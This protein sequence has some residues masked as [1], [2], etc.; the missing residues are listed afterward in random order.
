TLAGSMEVIRGSVHDLKDDSIDL[1]EAM[2][3]I[4]SDTPYEVHFYCGI[5]NTDELPNDVKY[6]FLMAAKEALTNTTK[7]SDATQIKIT[8]QEHPVL[9]QLRIHDNGSRPPLKT[10]GMGL[11]NI[12]SRVGG[13]G[14]YCTFSYENGF[15]IF[16]TLPKEK[17]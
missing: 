6:C 2:Q 3:S 16:I 12:E 15:K 17:A 8:L 11:G 1:A 14:G 10:E 7:H 4:F 5:E 13:A 9:Y